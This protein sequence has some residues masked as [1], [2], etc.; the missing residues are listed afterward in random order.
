LR[1]D[2]LCDT[3]QPGGYCTIFNCAGNSCPDNAACVLFH[4]AVQGCGYTDRQT[5]RTARTFCMASCGS[6]SDCRS[7]YMC[8]D[9]RNSPWNA[10]ILDD[11]QAQL[12]C[13]VPPDNGVVSPPA[14]SESDAAVCQ[15]TPP[16]VDA[17]I[18]L[19][20]AAIA[21]VDAGIEAE[22][23]ASADATGDGVADAPADVADAGPADAPGGGG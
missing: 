7:G 6:N 9:P 18:V 23:D 3:S 10:V 8:S 1:G 21:P 13:I 14:T 17:S 5:S 15:A 11:N 19:P 4:A 2:R 12:V 22:A 16:P 20:D